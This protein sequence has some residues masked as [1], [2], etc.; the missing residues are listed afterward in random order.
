VQDLVLRV[1]Q[2]YAQYQGARALYAAQKASVAEART[3]FEAADERRRT[4]VA[5]IADVLQAKT[6]LS[7][8]QLNLQTLDGQV[9]TLRGAVATAV[10]VPANVPVEA[11]ELPQVDIERQLARIEDLIAQAQRERPDLLRARMQEEAAK[12]HAQSVRARGW[13]Q[14]FLTGN[15]SALAFIVPGYPVGNSYGGALQLRWSIFTGFRDSFDA[16]QAEEQAKAAAARSDSVEQQAILSVWSSYQAVRTAVQRVR[17]ARDLLSSAKQS[18]DV[19]EGRYKEGVGNILDV[20]T[21]QSAL[22]GARAQEIQARADWQLSVASLAH[23][24][25]AL[26][27]AAPGEQK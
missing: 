12:S 13:P 26:G 19:A 14:L 8:A 6:A 17:T 10:G 3:A 23:D 1:E 16:A 7:Q 5:T 24:T 15:A 11:E 20:L 25:G 2:A 18:A 9:Q 4:G 21:A 27:P 22:A